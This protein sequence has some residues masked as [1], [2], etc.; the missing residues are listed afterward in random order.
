MINKYTLAIENTILPPDSY[1]QMYAPLTPT[2]C[3]AMIYA[4]FGFLSQLL[5][6]VILSPNHGA[7]HNPIFMLAMTLCCILV[8]LAGWILSWKCNTHFQGFSVLIAFI[9]AICYYEGMLAANFD[10]TDIAAM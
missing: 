2:L 10:Y 6:A 5:F 1:A 8:I 7:G 9:G 3:A 4:S